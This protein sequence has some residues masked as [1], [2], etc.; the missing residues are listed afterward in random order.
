MF[1]K[2]P[3]WR[4][5]IATLGIILLGTIVLGMVF[6]LLRWLWQHPHEL[7][8]SMITY[9]F[10]AAV[11]GYT[12]V[13]CWPTNWARNLRMRFAVWCV[14]RWR[15]L[16]SNQKALLVLLLGAAILASKLS[17]ITIKPPDISWPPWVW[18]AISIFLAAVF[19]WLAVFIRRRQRK[20]KPAALG[21]S[22]TNTPLPSPNL[23][24]PPPPP[25]SWGS[26]KRRYGPP[27][28]IVVMTI[29]L[30][31]WF[32]AS[33]ASQVH[34]TW[35]FFSQPSNLAWL[36]SW[37][38]LAAVAF[39]LFVFLADWGEPRKPNGLRSAAASVVSLGFF[40]ALILV[41]LMALAYVHQHHGY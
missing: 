10:I 11:I 2:F 9:G 14:V 22:Q 1:N 27:P 18:W 15:R 17:R 20:S 28:L 31:A 3:G 30:V 24:P 37:Q 34:W 39:A 6:G 4:S 13:M 16:S 40:L 29:G 36:T 25:Q 26:A 5:M 41:A 23:T 33:R 32:L 38:V 12:L 21:A 7:I 35:P 8:T 19:S